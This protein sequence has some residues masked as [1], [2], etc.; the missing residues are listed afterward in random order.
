MNW[1][2]NLFSRRRRYAELNESIRE[3][4]EEQIADLID[5]GMTRQQAEQAARRAFGN[6]TLIEQRGREVWQWLTLASIAADARFAV[7]QLIKSPGFTLTAVSTL[8]LGIAVN[9]TIFSVV[10]AWLMPDLPERDADK[11]VVVS[12]VKPD[13]TFLPD[14]HDIS[15]PA[16]AAVLADNKVFAQAAAAHDGLSGT[17]GGHND[18]PEAIHYAA[19]SPNYFNLFGA[20]PLLGRGFL[21]NEDQPEQS[22]VVVLSHGLWMRKFGS[23]PGIVGRTIRLNRTD[24]TVIGVMGADFRLMWLTPQL[25]TPLTI[26]AADLA[27]DARRARDLL[28]FARLAPHITLAQAGAEAK[29]LARRAAA[30][31][32]D[33]EGRWSASVRTLKDYL[34]RAYDIAQSL[35]VMM[36]GVAFVLLIACANV[37]GLLLTRAA[38]RQKEV[39]IRASLGASRWRIVRQLLIEGLTIASLGGTAGLALTWAGIRIMRSLLAFNEGI[40]AVSLNLDGK[41]LGFSAALTL[42]AAVLSSLVPAWRASHTEI[43]TPLKN[44]G[45]TA[46]AG[47]GRNRVRTLLVSAEIAIALFLLTGV[48]LLLRGIYALDH[49]PLGFRTDHLL[50]AGLTLDAR[51]PDAAS[52]ERFV[53]ELLRKAHQIVGV[54][55]AAVT[56]NLPSAGA[57]SVRLHI[58][59]LPDPPPSQPRT[60]EHAS[61]T[62]EFFAAAG[63]A[64]LYG[65]TFTEQDH[66][67]APRVVVVNQRFVERYLGRGDAV[68]RLVLLERNDAAPPAWARIIGVVSN[69]KSYSEETRVDPMVYE[70]FEQRPTTGMF[71]LMLHGQAT[72]PESMVPALRRL[73]AE[74]DPELPLLNV[75]SMDEVLDKQHDGRPAFMDIL[76]T[77]ACLALALAAIGIYGLIAYSVRQRTQEFGIRLALGAKPAAISTM[78]LGE[79]LKI[80]AIASSIG[81]LFALPLGRLFDSMFPG[82]EFAAPIVYPIV[83]ALTI[84][85][86]IAA[87]SV[88]ARRAM[89]VDPTT[90]LRSE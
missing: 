74:L 9:G 38:A 81:L 66:A 56:Q 54:E 85:I 31:Y 61:V 30:D 20:A 23:D 33:S 14:V 43:G 25:W 10:S 15:A 6:V 78:I 82:I 19:V 60:T 63:I 11:V 52:R 44:G 59:G 37:S 55:S 40:A 7:R 49:Q 48:G 62:S 84:V 67:S 27:P 51:Y 18:Q 32:P 90:A 12:A 42:L 2:G 16:Y 35:A 88:P 28:V 87:T 53:R 13:S 45:R 21:P 4:L 70:P 64:A 22:H 79:G 57:E 29:R 5:R 36:V 80:T 71:S 76:A 3:H 47:Q 75:M 34:L 39:A 58:Q 17:L 69:V 65:R 68:G 24:Y 50:T 72:T 26:T 46:T 1:L 41:V 86:A 77:F 89:R 73:V 83:L 8:A